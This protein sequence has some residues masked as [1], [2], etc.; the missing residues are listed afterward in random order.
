MDLFRKKIEP[1]S[2]ACFFC[3]YLIVFGPRIGGVF[4][5]SVLTSGVLLLFIL[6]KGQISLQTKKLSAILLL[7]IIDTFLVSCFSE[8]GVNLIFLLKFVRVLF[9][10]LCISNYVELDVVKPI[11]IRSSLI[12]VLLMHA[13]VIIIGSAFW[14]EFQNI[15]KPLSGFDRMPTFF[16]STGFTNGY[17][18]AGLLC[19]FGVLITYFS[20]IERLKMIKVI[21]FIVAAL[22]TSRVNM[23]LTEI[24]MVWLLFFSKGEKKI[25]LLLEVLFVFSLFPVLGIFLFTTQNQ[26]NFIVQMLL[27]NEFFANVS[28]KLVYYYATS[29]VDSSLS[30]HYNF[31]MLTNAQILFGSM[32]DAKLDPGYTQYIYRIG[33]LGTAVCLLFYVAVISN[34]WKIKQVNKQDAFIVICICLM[35]VVM[36]VKNSY[37]LARHVTETLL[38]MNFLLVKEYNNVQSLQIIKRKVHI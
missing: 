13:A 1:K 7:L 10:L 21:L 24:V 27:K 18:F 33:V 25:K 23:I 17:D 28:T 9:T 35:C 36:S 31:D 4:D 2:I 32:Q 20:K 29:S 14:P 34:A 15:L 19:L 38:V 11:V 26:D 3:I 12:N 16:R 37:L 6:G 30:Q 5:L 8:E 22:L